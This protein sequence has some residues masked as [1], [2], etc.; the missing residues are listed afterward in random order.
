[1][2]LSEKIAKLRKC[3]G[4]SQEDLAN[5]LDVSRQTVYKWESGLAL[6]ELEKLKNIAKRFEV[7]F[8]YLMDDEIESY[9]KKEAPR[10]PKNRG[11][12]YTGEE[13]PR[14]HADIDN[15]YVESRKAK[16][17]EDNG[18]F[19]I[20]EQVLKNVMEEIGAT[21]VMKIIPDANTACFYIKEKG[22]FGLYYSSKIQFVCPIENFIDFEFEKNSD[23]PITS[24]A[25]MT[26]LIFD[27]DG[28][29]G[30]GVGSI[31]Y[32]STISSNSASATLRYFDGDEVKEIN[33]NLAV[34]GLYLV[35]DAKGDFNFWNI[36]TSTLVEG[37]IK[38]LKVIRAKLSIEKKRMQGAAV[39]NMPPIDREYYDELNK[40]LAEGF[41]EHLEMLEERARSDNSIHGVGSFM[42]FLFSATVIGAFVAM[43]IALSV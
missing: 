28:L 41:A 34:G 40:E 31:P 14:N 12:Y 20:Q 26:N 29:D 30:I 36:L 6:P 23:T 25:R 8:D 24:R 10:M 27:E 3:E 2:K 7:S 4:L 42:K 11:V 33:L 9:E 15:G 32:Q 22:L 21:E 38:N 17:G 1:M 37:L 13:L 19:E 16:T 18:F 5:E 35:H 43:I 39:A